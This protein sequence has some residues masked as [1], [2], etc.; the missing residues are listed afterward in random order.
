[1]IDDVAKT[2]RAHTVRYTCRRWGTERKKI[3]FEIVA[4]KVILDMRLCNKSLQVMWAIDILLIIFQDITII[5][6]GINWILDI[7]FIIYFRLY[8]KWSENSS[9]TYSSSWTSKH[10]KIDH[11]ECRSSWV[12]CR[13]WV[14]LFD[15]PKSYTDYFST[16][17]SKPKNWYLNRHLW[18]YFSTK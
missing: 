14:S 1:M 12:H 5:S 10:P 11:G 16:I 15:P 4:R 18:G 9:T 2:G 13:S 6:L 3:Y 7:N 17:R 8:Q